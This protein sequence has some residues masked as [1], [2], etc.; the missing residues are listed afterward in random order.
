MLSDICGLAFNDFI[1][2]EN[3]VLLRDVVVNVLVVVVVVVVS[4]VI[5]LNFKC[6]N[7]GDFSLGLHAEPFLLKPY[8]V[9]R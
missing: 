5:A 4:S 1:R 9:K 2:C 3:I 8:I 6:E 7:V